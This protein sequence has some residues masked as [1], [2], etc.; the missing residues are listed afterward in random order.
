MSEIKLLESQ[1]VKPQSNKIKRIILF[2]HG[3][4]ADGSD[5]INIASQWIDEIHDTIFY[6]P[7]APFKCDMNPTGFQ[8]FELS[9][10]TPE[11]L[12]RGLKKSKPYLQNFINHILEKHNVEMKDLLVVGFSQGTIIS[13]NHL[14]TTDK[15]CAGIIGY[16]GLFYQGNEKNVSP[17]FPIFLYHGKDDEVI[18]YELSVN[19]KS[20]LEKLGFN[21][22]FRIC[23]NLGHGIDMEGINKGKEFIKKIFKV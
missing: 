2:L 9:E 8:W 4:G 5:L 10:R 19:A 16:S 15:A 6:S 21:V 23:D 11:E 14:T 1:V 7:N 18:N 12:E 22:D 17:R 20:N 13:L 3:Y